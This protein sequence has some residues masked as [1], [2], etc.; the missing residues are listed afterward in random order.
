M[1]EIGVLPSEA[2]A[3]QWRTRRKEKGRSKRTL[4]EY[5]QLI[6]EPGHGPLDF[7]RYPF[8]PGLYDAIEESGDTTFQK[9]T[10]V[11]VSTLGLRTVLWVADELGLKAMY[12]LPT[13][14]DAY[15]FSDDRM[16]PLIDGS[17]HL[18]DRVSAKDVQNKGLKRIGLG[19]I[20][21]RGSMSEHNLDSV[22]AEAIV[23]DEYNTLN[24]NNIP[25]GER[26]VGA[27]DSGG[28]ILRI[29]LAT[30]SGIGISARYDA[31]DQN[32]WMVRCGA[33]NEW[34][35][36]TWDSLR[37][38]E[39]GPGDYDVR[40][41]CTSCERDIDVR[42]GEWVA[43]FPER[44]KRGF[45]IPRLIVPRIDLSPVVAAG[46]SS[47]PEALRHHYNRDRALPFE[48]PDQRLSIDALNSCRREGVR[49][50]ASYLGMNPVTMG[51]D[52]STT[53]GLNVI[54][55]EHLNQRENR[56]LHAQVVEDESLGDTG[57][58]AGH[59]ALRQL[60][61]LLDRYR[62]NMACIDHLP[63]G[64]F[65]R[66]FANRHRG[67]VYLVAFN[68]SH[69]GKHPIVIPKANSADV[70]V[71]V[72]RTLFLDV[73]LGQYRSQRRLLPL[74]EPMPS[75]AGVA[76]YEDQLRNLV[77]VKARDPA[78]RDYYRYDEAGAIDWAMAELYD[79][80]ATEVWAFRLAE[81]SVRTL[82]QSE[83][84]VKHDEG[85]YGRSQ[86]LSDWEGVRDE[87]EYGPGGD[88]VYRP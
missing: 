29:G 52:Q 49:L 86:S 83:V 1:P 78:G 48:T 25:V 21:F 80:V 40:R 24:Q 26:R 58:E 13:D 31:S 32:R 38:V 87:D 61:E 70:T 76:S 65:A 12:V 41:V 11:G 7:R 8:Q 66:A 16:K 10:Q 62:V 68:T 73:L 77:K 37:W 19:A 60:S 34:Q 20:Y 51:I 56:I 18:L 22:P 42:K 28:K 55:R 30:I 50:E 15:D 75:R 59:S 23:F 36:I 63:D 2:F 9:G 81:G 67:R 45:H 3:Q 5:A 69:Q 35:Q 53:R 79:L 54:I 74:R 39:Q 71:T 88:D 64:L 47:D 4:L 72:M 44:R 85:L 17:D 33:C 82:T 6:A 14:D 27:A 84:E 57:P 46:L 43:S